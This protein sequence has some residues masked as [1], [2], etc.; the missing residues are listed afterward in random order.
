MYGLT[1]DCASVLENIGYFTDDL[2]CRSAASGYASTFGA[3]G[4]F[5]PA[6]SSSALGGLAAAY[7]CQ[8]FTVSLANACTWL[9]GCASSQCAGYSY[10]SPP[11]PSPTPTTT[12]PSP[13]Q[14]S[15]AVR[16]VLEQ[17]GT[18]YSDYYVKEGIYDYL[19]GATPSVALANYH[20]RILITCEGCIWPEGYAPQPPPPPAAGG[21]RLQPSNADH[22][23]T[24]TVTILAEDEAQAGLIDE[25]MG[26]LLADVATA[27]GRLNL[28][29]ELN[30]AAV[31]AT[32]ECTL[33]GGSC[34]GLAAPGGG[35]GGD[36]A[37]MVV[38]LL[39]V[40]ILA[41]IAAFV[42]RRL[43]CQRAD[44]TM[45][46]KEHH[47]GGVAMQ[48]HNKKSVRYPGFQADVGRTDQLAVVHGLHAQHAEI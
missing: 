6:T 46:L 13:P 23:I 19:R 38:A 44:A 12:A 16:F 9:G 14:S 31:T 30:A 27:G 47:G 41:G 40:A 10:P 36:A 39:G 20:E 1:L 4:G 35:G 32:G 37:P 42:L 45:L 43:F 17:S 48:E 34:L 25:L 33:E 22:T 24:L 8:T 11:P 21:R 26:A 18:A 29:G 2:Y 15:W 7:N 28:Y 5:C 3:A